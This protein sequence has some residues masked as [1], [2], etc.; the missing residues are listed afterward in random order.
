ME[1]SY[2]CDTDNAYHVL[3]EALAQSDVVALL[4]K[5]TGRESVLVGVAAGEALV[6]HVEEGKVTL[7]LHDVAD[8]APLVL[9]G[10][11]TG[12]V[13]STGV[14]QDDAVVG[15]GLDVGD[16]ALKVQADGVLVVVAVLLHLQ[17]GVLEDGVVVGPAGV[18]QVDLLRV[19]VEA[20][21]ERTADSQGTGAGDG[22]GDDE[23]AVLDDGRVLAIGQLRGGAG[24][25][26]DTGDAGIFLV[27]ARGNDLVLG[28]ADGGENV[29]LALVITY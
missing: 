14:Q 21:Q 1:P 25:R 17:A 10:I 18:G 15:G 11:D 2:N 3:G 26:R 13:V 6:G 24:E 4:D 9:S 16:Q 7:L 5:V 8:L 29:G 27:A 20:L 12:G 23:T 28:G 22:L 19:G